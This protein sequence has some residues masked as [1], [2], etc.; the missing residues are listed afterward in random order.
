MTT[1]GQIERRFEIREL[2]KQDLLDA[3]ES[4]FFKNGFEATSIAEI[5]KAAE[6]SKKTLYTYFDS[7]NQIYFEIM[8]RGYKQL[9]ELIQLQQQESHPLNSAQ[10]FAVFWKAL[11][12]FLS[13]YEGY[14]NAIIFFEIHSGQ[15]QNSY[16]ISEYQQLKKELTDSLLEFF[17]NKTDVVRIKSGLIWQ[18]VLGTAQNALGNHEKSQLILQSGYKLLSSMI[19]AELS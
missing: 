17:E 13:N 8:L 15:V 5:A 11:E 4:K 3:A 19:S 2:K 18:F 9:L 16:K 6:F 14:L 12:N 1:L 10:Q 7:K